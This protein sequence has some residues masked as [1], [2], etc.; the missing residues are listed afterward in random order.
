MPLGQFFLSKR[1]KP[2]QP[3]QLILGE[4]DRFFVAGVGEG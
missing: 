4:D 3:P 1:F 2:G